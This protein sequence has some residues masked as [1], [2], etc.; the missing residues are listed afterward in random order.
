MSENTSWVSLAASPSRQCFRMLA[1]HWF[2]FV[3]ASSGR[4]GLMM[5]WSNPSCRPSLVIASILSV[6]AST[7]P[8]WT[9]S[10][11]LDSSFTRAFWC[12]VGLQTTVWYSTSGTFRSSWSA[13]LMSATSRN[14][15]IS[16]GRLK[17]LAKRVL[18]R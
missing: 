18:A 10:A 12:S 13:V 7:L 6:W 14:R 11:R 15:F 5:R 17:N 2:T 9:F 16:S 3:P 4:A 8:E 1:T